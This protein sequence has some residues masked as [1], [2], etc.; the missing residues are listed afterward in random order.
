[1]TA[2]IATHRFGLGAKPSENSNAEHDPIGYV[3]AQLSPLRFSDF[4]S[5]VVIAKKL[6]SFRVN[7]KEQKKEDRN[8]KDDKLKKDALKYRQT[9]YRK[10][11]TNTLEHAI[12][13]D[14]SFMW[15]MLDFFSNHFSVTAQGPLLTALAGNLE[16]EAIAP[17][18]LGHFSEMLLA[19]SQHPVMLN[20]LNNEQ[21]FGANSKLGKKGKGLN[22]NLAREILEL[23][24]L[25][26]NGGYTQQDVIALANGISGWS[27]QNPKK[28]EHSLFVFRNAGH[29]P[30][31]QTLLD[32]A[33]KQK[34]INQGTAM[35]EAI[36]AHPSTA[37]HL[38]MK[39]ARHVVSDSPPEA[40]VAALEKTW[41]NTNG[42]L[43]AVYSTLITHPLAWEAELQKFKTPREYF[44]STS[45]A[46]GMSKLRDGMVVRS[47]RDMGQSPH[48]AGN[49]AGYEDTEAFWNNGY[50]ILSRVDWISQLST[51]GDTDIVGLAKDLLGTQLTETTHQLVRRAESR[52]RA[53]ALL[54]LSPEFMRR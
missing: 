31:P 44:I 15:R 30:G 11:S 34:G 36:A 52:E 25:G 3:S 20:Y 49:P 53:F 33:F 6:Q 51:K 23:H 39:L 38:S 18:L 1:M 50:A 54:F 13:S 14:R 40:L 45:R 41:L 4:P 22:E 48:K 26:V 32:K 7:K 21:S 2:A 10:L 28:V 35:L 29:E 47:L 12:A 8:E 5:S 43:K 16:R 37:R 27:I 17:H 19:V 9:L 42:D 46:L 24:T